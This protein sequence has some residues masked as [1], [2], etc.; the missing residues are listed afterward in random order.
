ME[1][2]EQWMERRYFTIPD[3]PQQTPELRQV[4]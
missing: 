1:R 2:N 3:A 4:A